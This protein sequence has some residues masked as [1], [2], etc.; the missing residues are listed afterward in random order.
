MNSLFKTA[1]S[2]IHPGWSANW[3]L[4][5]A[6]RQP[7]PACSMILA[8][9]RPDHLIISYDKIPMLPSSVTTMLVALAQAPDPRAH[10][11]ELKQIGRA[12]LERPDNAAALL[13]QMAG[14]TTTGHDEKHMSKLLSTVLD[15]ARMARENGQRR[16]G[17]ICSPRFIWSEKGGFS[18][19]M[20][21]RSGLLSPR[22]CIGEA[23]GKPSGHG[24]S[25][26]QYRRWA[27]RRFA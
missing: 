4:E 2:P 6:G 19:L 23:R 22:A 20:Q 24:A 17:H 21:T 16:G 12:L 8:H 9:A 14:S 15:E 5:A 27:G 1:T 18:I 10:A 25:L 7:R 3:R 13:A 11:A 26:R